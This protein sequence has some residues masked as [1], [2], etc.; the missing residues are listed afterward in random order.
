MNLPSSTS[1]SND[2]YGHEVAEL[3]I[4]VYCMESLYE[5]ISH[6]EKVP[7]YHMAKAQP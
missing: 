6:Q 5:N 7:D 4:V 1:L 3:L 2:L